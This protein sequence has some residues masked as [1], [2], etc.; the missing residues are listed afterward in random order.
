MC[1]SICQRIVLIFW[2]AD[3]L[4]WFTVKLLSAFNQ[5]ALGSFLHYLLST[6]QETRYATECRHTSAA[7]KVNFTSFKQ[8]WKCKNL[9][10][11]YKTNSVQ[12][13][14][15]L[16]HC[17]KVKNISNKQF[18]GCNC[19]YVETKKLL[20]E[21]LAASTTKY[22]FLE[23]TFHFCI[24]LFILYNITSFIPFLCMLVTPEIYFFFD[25][26]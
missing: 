8:V 22:S 10:W 15:L 5:A 14:S 17:G 26:L 2:R 21:H 13:F 12:P 19:K 25:T 20:Q 7:L 11:S 16:S 24:Y 4:F 1:F 6:K 9:E 3:A 18:W 23:K